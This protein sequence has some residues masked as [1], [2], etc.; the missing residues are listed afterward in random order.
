MDKNLGGAF[1]WSVEM[2]DFRGTCGEADYPLLST[3][4]KVLGYKQNDV[5]ANT[6]GKRYSPTDEAKEP[7]RGNKATQRKGTNH[8]F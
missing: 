5:S 7:P 6:A 4:N 8:D 1:I 3:I 2:D